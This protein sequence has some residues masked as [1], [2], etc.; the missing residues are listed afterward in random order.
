M[1]QR[2]KLNPR[3]VCK[4]GN[5]TSSYLLDNTQSGLHLRPLPSELQNAGKT[6]LV[7]QFTSFRL[8]IK[9]ELKK[10]NL[11]KRH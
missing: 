11:R 2:E 9:K 8:N 10:K 3:T 6:A 1:Q 5:K 7:T 4:L